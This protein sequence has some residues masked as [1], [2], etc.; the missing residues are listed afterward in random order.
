MIRYKKADTEKELKQ[1][2]ALQQQNLKGSISAKE[3]KDEGFVTVHH[4]FDLLLRMNNICPHIIAKD[5]DEV[6]GYALCMDPQFGDEIDVLKPMFDELK[7][8][9]T[10][11]KIEKFLVMGQV[12]IDKGYRRQGIF[13]KLY[14]KMKEEVI[15]PFNC[16][17]TEV[18]QNNL[19]S[20]RAHLGI[21]FKQLSTYHSG[22]INWELIA[23]F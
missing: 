19:R 3:G 7:L 21:G 12:C 5:N 17:I 13:R 2:L 23:L 15:P 10:S 11:F 18:D 9:S 1:I 20:L 6:I 14:E 8:H 22:G 4:D 16:I